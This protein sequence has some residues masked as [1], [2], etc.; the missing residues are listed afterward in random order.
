MVWILFS[1]LFWPEIKFYII[2]VFVF[3]GDRAA[4]LLLI[5]TAESLR[6][7]DDSGF[8]STIAG[9]RRWVQE[10]LTFLPLRGQLISVFV[11]FGEFNSI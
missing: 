1:S 2:K 7:P 11:Q 3:F 9:L 10:M 8:C 6:F 5:K 4:D